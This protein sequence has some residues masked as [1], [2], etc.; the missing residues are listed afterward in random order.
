MEFSRST[1]VAAHTSYYAFIMNMKDVNFSKATVPVPQDFIE[2]IRS[3]VQ[4]MKEALNIPMLS[5]EEKEKKSNT[6]LYDEINLLLRYASHIL[7]ELKSFKLIDEDMMVPPLPFTYNEL[8]ENNL[9]L[10]YKAYS[11]E[12]PYTYLLTHR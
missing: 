4:L 9:D 8:C 7:D 1:L 5:N 12:D 6:E 2:R 10:L 11:T 3:P